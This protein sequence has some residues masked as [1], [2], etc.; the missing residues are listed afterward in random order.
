MA[1]FNELNV[2]FNDERFFS[3]EI[4]ARTK[5]NPNEA[6]MRPCV[7]N[8]NSLDAYASKLTDKILSALKA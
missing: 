1:Y 3:T 7:K 5:E 6:L 4:S 8:T 2:D